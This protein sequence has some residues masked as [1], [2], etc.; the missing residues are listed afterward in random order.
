M[1]YLNQKK[2]QEEDKQ[3]QDLIKMDLSADIKENLK[4]L[5][6]L[7]EGCSDK[8]IKE[9]TFGREKQSKGL[10]VFFDGLVNK[11]QIEENILRPI[12]LELNMMD[13][14][15]YIEHQH[16]LLEEIK[17]KILVVAE[18]KTL[19]T[20]E[21]VCHHISSGDTVVLLDGVNQGLIAGTRFWP[22]RAVE[23]PENEAVIRG[24]KEGFT[25]TLRFNTALL[26]R[27]LK[28]TEF[29]I[30]N[31]VLGRVT[32]TDVVICYVKSICPPQL[33]AEV[34]KR[35]EKI[36]LDGVLDTGYLEGYL[37]DSPNSFF[38]QTEYTEKPD[39]ACGHLL[40]GRI[41]IMVDGS[42]MALILPASFP[43]MINSGEDYYERYIPAS[44]FRLM[45]IIAYC[46]ALLLP[47][48]YVATV[49]F[50]HEMIPASLY[51]TISSS[52]EGVPF[53]S[54]FEALLLEFTFEMLREAGL[55]LPG[56]IGPAVSIVGALIIGDAAVQAGLVST[57][58]V[59]VIA[60][61]GVAS[62]VTPSYSAGISIRLIR[63]AMLI[64]GG[65]L[66]FFGIVMAVIFLLIHMASLNSFGQSY[67]FPVAPLNKYELTDVFVRRPWPKNF[68]RP[69]LA[70]N[71]NL[72]RQGK[73]P[74]E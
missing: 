10:V 64:A 7:L 28:S 44:L 41:C 17:E 36:D 9:F 71:K 65:V 48:L 22:T 8:V 20:L 57:P 56:S 42:P 45:R 30:E 60:F 29:K 33:V 27:R 19:S 73:S 49:S 11:L 40:E 6:I 3:P 38:P 21:E 54:I 58:M 14:A 52:R 67:L 32:K 68:R 51:L 15:K 2:K 47:G 70:G 5:N 43:D 23:N 4:N 74:Q 18:V 61:T 25:E 26:R 12:M 24:P 55:R 59:V 13:T 72:I 66:G 46:V 35:L 39:R 53:P 37:E 50:H 63:F 69:R 1:R 62:F 16:D 34:K 31:M